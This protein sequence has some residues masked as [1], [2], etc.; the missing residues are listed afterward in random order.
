MQ[1]LSW[2]TSKPLPEGLSVD[3]HGI[4]RG[5][6]F[7]PT[8]AQKVALIASNSRGEASYKMSIQARRRR[9]PSPTTA[10]LPWTDARSH[11]LSSHAYTPPPMR[12]RVVRR[13][14]LDTLPFT[15]DRCV[16][17]VRGDAPPPFSY[18]KTKMM[19]TRGAAAP[20][21]R[22]R[23]IG[24]A[25]TDARFSIKPALPDGLAIDE[26][27]ARARSGAAGGG[28]F[29]WP[30]LWRLES[31]LGSVLGLA[32]GW[33]AVHHTRPHVAPPPGTHSLRLLLFLSPA[34]RTTASSSA[35]R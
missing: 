26:A 13:L 33:R 1:V 9:R 17:Q 27:H 28:C 24:K 21:N 11:A 14:R 19:L 31:R 25:T 23:S 7:L 18:E 10:E 30:S 15:R 3:A 6:P 2:R 34:R 12:T 20:K 16:L 32:R 5:V 22:P 35:R 29:V 4:I 8:K